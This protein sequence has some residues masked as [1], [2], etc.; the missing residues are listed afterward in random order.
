MEKSKSII[1]IWQEMDIRL[2]TPH[3]LI[4]GQVTGDCSNC[5]EVGIPF[6]AKTCPKCGIDFKY[7]GTRVSSSAKEAKR[8]HH[9][10]PDLTLVELSDIKEIQARE[11]ARG[12]L[13]D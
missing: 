8:L 6:E 13:G 4:A 1:R 11:K 7:M 2:I 10:R 9:K 12:F 3:M 5:K